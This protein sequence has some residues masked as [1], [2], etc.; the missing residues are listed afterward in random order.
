MSQN[1]GSC[2]V[3]MDKNGRVLMGVRKNAYHSGWWGIPGGRIEL[4]EGVEETA[5]RELEEETGL[6]AKKL[7]LVGVVRDNQGDYDFIHFAY[8]CS[9]YEGEVELREP[10]KCE[11]WEWISKDNLP[12]KLLRGH[13]KALE[14]AENKGLMLVDCP[15]EEKL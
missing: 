7:K 12:S 14:L 9:E 15:F 10:E 5:R 11:R 2:V 4:G 3:V 6:V 8:V 1:L 13:V